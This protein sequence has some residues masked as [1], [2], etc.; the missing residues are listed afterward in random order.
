MYSNGQ[1]VVRG[2]VQTHKWS[3]LAMANSTGE[4]YEDA[5]GNRSFVEEKMTP[6]Q[7]A[8]AQRLAREWQ[9]RQPYAGG[10]VRC[11][12][13]CV[14]R[15]GPELSAWCRAESRSVQ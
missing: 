14:R 11:G 7:V 2:Y 9:V 6:Q 13:Q 12:L 1:G 10:A 5:A 3:N 15:P 4:A 8:E